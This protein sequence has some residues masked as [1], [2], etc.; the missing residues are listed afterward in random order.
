MLFSCIADLV[1]NC[2]FLY[3]PVLSFFFFLC[4]CVSGY[5]CCGIVSCS[6]NDDCPLTEACLGGACQHPCDAHNPCAFNA[7][8]INTN[9]GTDCSCADGYHGNG[10]VGCAP[11]KVFCLW[12]VLLFVWSCVFCILQKYCT[13]FCTEWNRR[14]RLQSS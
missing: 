13:F 12:I 4:T 7:I 5:C 14:F 8:C 3:I 2:C 9:H 6:S 10:Y 11:G 1:E